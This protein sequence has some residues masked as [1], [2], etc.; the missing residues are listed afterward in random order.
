MKKDDFGNRM[1][2]YEIAFRHILPRRLPVILRIDGCHF[3]RILV[4]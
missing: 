1:K 3:T 2:D 4:V